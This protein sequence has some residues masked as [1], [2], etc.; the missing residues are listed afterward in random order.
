[1]ARGGGPVHIHEEDLALRLR[2]LAPTAAQ[3]PDDLLAALQQVNESCVELFDVSGS[4]IMIA[5][6]QNITHYVSASDGPG[7]YLEQAES[8]T[9]EGP[10]TEAFVHNRVVGTADITG[11]RRWPELALAMQGRG[12]VAVLGVPVVLGGVP[13]G[14]LDVYRSDAHRWDE[15][16]RRSLARYSGVVETVL[17]SALRAHTAGQ[18][19]SQLQYA[20]DYRV[21]IE[22]A[23]GYLMAQGGIDGVTAFNRLRR[24]ARSKRIKVGDVAEQL[25]D[26]G[27]LPLASS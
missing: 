24:V 6:E 15:S 21:V 7:R 20:L 23:V 4:G 1:M 9:G 14:T 22:R 17:T 27:Q 12:V 13:V 11:D 5:D 26:T 25:L 2:R 18:L 19:A 10:C 8:S 16:D 3:G